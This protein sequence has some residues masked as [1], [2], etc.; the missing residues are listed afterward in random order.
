MPLMIR[1]P[2]SHDGFRHCRT[3][4]NVAAAR[5]AS[6]ISWAATRASGLWMAVR[7]FDDRNE[8][9][10]EP[11][12]RGNPEA[13]QELVLCGSPVRKSARD[14]LPP[15]SGELGLLRSPASLRDE[16]HQPVTA[17]RLERPIERRAL[18]HL[19]LG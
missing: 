18:E 17:Q 4:M 11:S 12:P 13:R 10:G 15:A 9:R 16:L 5:R 14:A 2:G 6:L 3:T 7:R 8:L 1:R 19:F